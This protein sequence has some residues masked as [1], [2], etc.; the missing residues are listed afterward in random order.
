MPGGELILTMEKLLKL[1]NSLLKLAVKKTDSIKKGDIPSLNQFIKD[2]QSH[3][4]AIGKVE[5]DRL[6]I[7]KQLVREMET[8][9]I[10]D[11][12]KVMNGEEGEVL[13]RLR[14]E[15]LQVVFQIQE[16]NELNQQLIYQSLQFVNLSM[17]LINPKIEEFNYGHPSESQPSPGIQKGIFNSKA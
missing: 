5:K 2:E 12:L 3:I 6:V 13:E 4:A 10:S 1:H 16:K 7:A 8:P 11:C 9:S 14:D 17:S 15:L